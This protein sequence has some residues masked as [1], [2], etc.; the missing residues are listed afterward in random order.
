MARKQVLVSVPTNLSELNERI[1]LVGR[2]SR[3][4][5]EQKSGAEAA[6]ARIK[7]SS[8]AVLAPIAE[9][10]EREISGIE[11]FAEANRSTLLVGDAKSIS[12]SAGRIGWRMSPMRVSF[13][14]K[15]AERALAFLEAHKMKKYLRVVTEIDKEALL[16]DRPEVDGVKYKQ[17]DE[18]FVEPNREP[19]HVEAIG[20]VIMVT[21]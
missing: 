8:T 7:L 11:K 10:L 1:A 2:L 19:T 5:A 18:F 6:I 3:Q 14:K 4:L 9:Q 16:K 21:K 17:G 12:L 15:G 20:E 13:L